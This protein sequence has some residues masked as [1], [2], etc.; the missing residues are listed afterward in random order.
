MAEKQTE[1]ET[2]WLDPSKNVFS[3]FRLQNQKL[4]SIEMNF[5]D[6]LLRFG[7][8][9]L[10]LIRYNCYNLAL[11]KIQLAKGKERNVEKLYRL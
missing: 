10:L 5:M 7:T 4:F 2:R 11:H 8:V 6:I 9:L 3:E 1:Y